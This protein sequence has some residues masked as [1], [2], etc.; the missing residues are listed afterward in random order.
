[1]WSTIRFGATRQLRVLRAI[2]GNGAAGLASRITPKQSPFTIP[3][4]YRVQFTPRG[5][6]GTRGRPRKDPATKKAAS[7]K[8]VKRGRKPAA[9]KVLSEEDKTKLE[10]RKLKEVAL[11]KEP[12]KLPSRAWVVYVVQQTKGTHTERGHLGERTRQLGQEFKA[13][14]ASEIEVCLS[15]F[16]LPRAIG[17]PYL[18][19]CLTAFASHRQPEQTGQRGRVQVL[20]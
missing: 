10:I 8:P 4:S 12:A 14:S 5:Y 16:E 17:N 19:V 20:G 15:W 13:L 11:L 7:A 3:S 2:S 9:K 6:A 1:M 18:T